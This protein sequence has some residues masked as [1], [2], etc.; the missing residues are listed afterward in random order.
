MSRGRRGSLGQQKLLTQESRRMSTKI[1]ARMAPAQCRAAR[2]LLDMTQ[3]QLAKA[4]ELGLS[5]V[6]DFE[7]E[8]R[9][10]SD[11]ATK[12]MRSA[13]ERFGVEFIDENGGGPGVRLRKRQQKKGLSGGVERRST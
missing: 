4:A 8:R 2:A 5:T 7:R 13:L 3:S 10:V 1:V 6:V 12:T 11:E 9:L